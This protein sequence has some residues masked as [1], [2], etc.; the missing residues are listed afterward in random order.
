VALPAEAW[1]LFVAAPLDPST[2]ETLD[3][4]LAPLR[5]RFPEVR[6]MTHDLL[7]VTLVFVGQTDSRRVERIE[8][9]LGEVAARHEPYRATAGEAG[10]RVDAR[11]SARRGGVVWLI[12]RQGAAEAAAL[13]LDVDHSLGTGTYDE[14][15]RPRPHLTVARNASRDALAALRRASAS[16]A[17]AWTVDRIVLFRSHTGPRGSRYEA[18]DTFA[19]TGRADTP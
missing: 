14:R 2:A 12:L 13:S 3:A 5:S 4:E 17:L 1:R 18:L 8:T 19:L 11:P 16:L 9:V 7:H 6:W 10:G 15:H